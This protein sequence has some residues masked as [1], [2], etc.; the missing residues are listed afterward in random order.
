MFRVILWGIGQR[1]EHLK[2]VFQ[3]E[4]LRSEVEIIGVIGAS[5]GDVRYPVLDR[6]R[7]SLYEYDFII[8]M[9]TRYLADILDELHE[10]SVPEEKIIDGNVLAIHGFDLRRFAGTHSLVFPLKTETF[11]ELSSTIMDRQFV[12]EQ[13]HVWIGTK[14]YVGSMRLVFGQLIYKNRLVIGRYCSFSANIEAQFAISGNHNYH[15]V[16]TMPWPAVPKT[17]SIEV[18]NDVWIGRSVVLK[19][20]G[21]D[22]LT[23]GDGAVVAANSVV[24]D[25]V[26]PYAIV[27][28]NPARL[29]KYRFDE[30]TVARL[31]AMKWWN[32]P[33]QK[34]F[35]AHAD[36]E[37]VGGF[38]KKYDREGNLISKI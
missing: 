37:D 10:K 5:G 35:R 19:T 23:I 33:W 6:E 21:D 4:P 1:Y 26:P 7:L 38:L 24:V 2:H 18:G 32:W 16:T 20:K 12:N 9:S 27:G 17:S 31:L 29:I 15:R 36:M 30:E 13:I 14:S 28:G 34:V 8:V 25:D 3:E 11:Q 22:R